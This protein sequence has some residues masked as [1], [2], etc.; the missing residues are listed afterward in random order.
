L[1]N[2]TLQQVKES[3][4]DFLLKVRNV[5]ETRAAC[6]NT[7]KFTKAGYKKYI[8]SQ[9]DKHPKNSHWVV[10]WKK[11]KVGHAKII[12]QNIGI[13]LKQEYASKG[14]GTKLYHVLF[15][16]AKTLGFSKV[17]VVIKVNQPVAL[18]VAIKNGFNMIG[19]IWDENSH[20]YAWKT[21]K[22]L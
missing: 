4:W 6:N 9:L 13:L 5:P 2:V 19:M 11:K 18:W 8:Q 7:S 22:K 15:K 20:P 14:I 10:M 16:K 12:N 21:E 3:D 1:G 17:Y